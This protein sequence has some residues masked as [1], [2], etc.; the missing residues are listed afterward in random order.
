MKTFKIKQTAS[1]SNNEEK[2]E[3]SSMPCVRCG[4]AVK[5][6]KYAV[7][8]VEGDLLALSTK[9]EADLEDSGYLGFYPVGSECKKHI[10]AEFIHKY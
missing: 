8:L 7:Q 1:Y 5:N 6:N 2:I 10:P 4:K 3:D 9:E